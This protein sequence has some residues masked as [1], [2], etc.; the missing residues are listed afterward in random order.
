MLD[1]EEDGEPSKIVWCKGKDQEAQ[2][3]KNSNKMTN[4]VE[5]KVRENPVYQEDNKET[6]E[7]ED[8]GAWD[9]KTRK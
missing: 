4:V 6:E 1:G 5:K 8:N 9:E 7:E 3:N 2:D